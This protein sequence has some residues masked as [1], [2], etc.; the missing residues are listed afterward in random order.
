MPSKSFIFTLI[1]NCTSIKYITVK[2]DLSK[3]FALKLVKVINYLLKHFF[4][5]FPPLDYLRLCKI[6]DKIVLFL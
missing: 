1:L 3:S 2:D 4:G 6:T 5:V